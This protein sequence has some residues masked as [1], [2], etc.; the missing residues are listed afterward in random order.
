ML[1]WE[2]KN[3]VIFTEDKLPVQLI[4]VIS[5]TMVT[6]SKC[7]PPLSL[8]SVVKFFPSELLI[9]TDSWRHKKL[10]SMYKGRKRKWS[11]ERT[12]FILFYLL[13]WLGMCMFCSN[14]LLVPIFLK[15][16]DSWSTSLIIIFMIIYLY[17]WF[18][19][20]HGFVIP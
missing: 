13:V 19:I 3:H 15:Q 8:W 7:L 18:L 2:K 14:W 16:M 6:D 9:I 20:V 11:F 10:N 17:S 5:A 1:N 12:F 4:F